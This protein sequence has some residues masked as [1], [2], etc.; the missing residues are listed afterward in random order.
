MSCYKST[1]WRLCLSNRRSGGVKRVKNPL[2][3]TAAQ[4]AIKEK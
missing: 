4:A 3:L 1:I 2:S